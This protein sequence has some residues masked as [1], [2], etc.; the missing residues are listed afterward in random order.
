MLN[1]SRIRLRRLELRL[2]QDTVGETIGQ[3][4]QYMSALERGK[5]RYI[6][7]DTFVKLAHALQVPLEDLLTAEGKALTKESL[8]G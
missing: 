6:T 5:I 1:T 4:Q 3:D 7:V 8:H 2:S